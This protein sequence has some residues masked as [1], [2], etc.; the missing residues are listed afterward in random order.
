MTQRSSRVRKPRSRRLLKAAAWGCGATAVLLTG[1]VVALFLLIGGA[2][3]KSFPTVEN[4]IP[5]R[6][7]GSDRTDE[8]EGYASPYLGHTG[9]W[10]GK[11]GAIF[12]ASRIPSLDEEVAMG[13]RWTFMCVYWKAMEPD[14]PVDPSVGLPSAWASLDAFVSAAHDR[15]LHILM[16]APV[17]GG[18]AGGPPAW[19][20]RREAGKSAPADMDALA[21]FAGKLA[22]RYGPGGT[23]ARQRGWE[24]DYGVRAWELDN[25]PESYFTHW[26][27]QAADY[28]EF[29]TKASACIKQADPHAL[30]LTPA[31]AAGHHAVE[32]IEGA[33]NAD[34]RA[35]SEAFRAR[36]Q[37][38]S[39]GPVTDVVTFH[40]YE[41]LDT[42]F[43]GEDVPV[44]R[45]F[46]Q[47]RSVFE[48]WENRCAGFEYERKQEYW[49][50]EGNFDFI[51]ALSE[52]RR[53]A[54]RWQFFSRAFA[55]GIRKVTVMD[56]QPLEQTA[57]RTYVEALPNPFPMLPASHEVRLVL[58][59]IHAFRHPEGGERER[60]QIWVV[61]AEAGSGEAIAEIPVA[62]ATAEVLRVD[63]FRERVAAVDGRIRLEL[64]GDAKMP[65]PLLVIDRPE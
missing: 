22:Q 45:T 47:V 2:V 42:F 31:V 58:G 51:G 37:S 33:L 16:Q 24:P 6:D 50:T 52:K 17:V 12:G 62:H 15:R 56:A 60:G 23:L 57:V 65:P 30:I 39:I 54:W 29:V 43:A 41:G 46:Q 34:A 49:H 19:A 44:T 48:A 8:G 21:Q 28:A 55:A 20:G 7:S 32:W 5:P 27:G 3:P 38:Y 10:D 35:G 61:W 13:L 36:R 25:E 9:S 40:N 26:K 53:A 4:P 18:N 63:G 14:G 59:E 1:A 64:E 11:G